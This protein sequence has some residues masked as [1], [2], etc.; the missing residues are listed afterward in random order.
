M[1]KIFIVLGISLFLFSC[2]EDENLLVSE[3]GNEDNGEFITDITVEDGYLNFSSANAFEDFISKIESDNNGND[4]KVRSTAIKTDGFVSIIN[5]KSHIAKS[6]IS[7]RNNNELEEMTLDEFNIIKAEKLLPDPILTFI[8]DTTLRIGIEDRIYKITEYGTFSALKINGSNIDEAIENF[9]LEIIN[10]NEKVA[11]TDLGNNVTF[12]NSFGEGS[13]NEEMIAMPPLVEEPEAPDLHNNYNVKTYKWENN[14]VWQKMWD[15]VKRG[16]D[17]SKENDFSSDRR[18][19]VNVFNVNYSFYAS[20]GINVKMQK[21]KKFLFVSYWVNT[22]A[23]KLALGF[24]KVYGEMKYTNPRSFSNINPTSS[25]N[26]G[27]FQASINGIGSTYI[28]G[29]YNSFDIV[30]DWVDDIYMFVPEIKLMGTIYPNKDVMNKLYNV[31]P[32]YIFSFLKKQ[33]G[34]YIYTPIKK[35]I[36]PSDPRMAYYVWGDSS[37]DFKKD[38]SYIFGVKEYDGKRSSKSVRFDQSFGFTINNGSISGFVPSE[39][40]IKDL[41]VFGAAYYNG[42]WKGV[43]LIK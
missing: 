27:S 35:Q 15:K 13:M 10:I 24:N 40:I 7:T 37:N 29:L 17:V 6:A 19:Q 8:L 12:I 38:K 36:K 14:S 26:W 4:I 2:N 32:A 9:D 5:L 22:D 42:Q 18:V 34:Q 33:S 43:R 25:K 11:Y 30:K 3:G 23:D 39:F 31:P 21:R 1:R 20:S 16:K 28:Y 41:D